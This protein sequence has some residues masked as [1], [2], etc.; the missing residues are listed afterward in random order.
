MSRY[1][2]L[3]LSQHNQQKARKSL[4]IPCPQLSILLKSEKVSGKV[5][6]FFEPGIEKL[7]IYF[8]VKVSCFP[9][10]QIQT[11]KIK[12]VRIFCDNVCLQ[13]R[14]HGKLKIR[15]RS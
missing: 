14:K 4:D 2:I 1:R 10:K 11:R 8:V 15:L 6:Q 12:K 9:E 13:S 3:L 7:I 5:S